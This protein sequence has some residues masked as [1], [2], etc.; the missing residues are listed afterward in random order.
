MMRLLQEENNKRACTLEGSTV[1]L[2]FFAIGASV[3]IG[4]YT[5]G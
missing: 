4:C 5:P 3:A 2:D 1:S